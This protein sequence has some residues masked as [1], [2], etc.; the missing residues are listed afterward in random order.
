M[1]GKRKS[2]CGVLRCGIGEEGKRGMV[3]GGGLSGIRSL[4]GIGVLLGNSLS[5]LAAGLD[6]FET[7]HSQG[8][9]DN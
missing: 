1:N 2:I 8:W 9:A 7:L 5:A 6:A 4:C 3:G